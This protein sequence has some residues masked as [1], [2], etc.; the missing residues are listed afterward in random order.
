MSTWARLRF[1]ALGTSMAALVVVGA[2][3]ILGPKPDDPASDGVSLSDTGASADGASF[4]SGKTSGDS[5][6]ADGFS[7]DSLTPVPSCDGEAGATASC[8]AAADAHDGD[9]GDVGDVGDAPDGGDSDAATGD[10]VEGGG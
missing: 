2:A 4:D 1:L 3:C 5:D 7:A 10:V 8:D 9:A 6:F